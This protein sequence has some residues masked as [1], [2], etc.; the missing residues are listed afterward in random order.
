MT[1]PFSPDADLRN[2]Q[3]EFRLQLAVVKHLERAYP[4][5]VW[6][7]CPNR[8]G[9]AKDGYMKKLMGSKAGVPDI[10]CWWKDG[11]AGI[12]LKAPTGRLA[13]QQNKFLSALHSVGVHTVVC[14]SVKEVHEALKSWGLKPVCDGVVEADLRSDTQKKHDAFEYFKPEVE[15]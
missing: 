4:T 10:L 5:L 9:D 2:T 11:A 1:N 14:K 15:P 12:E 7:H 8:P 3:R 6:T 13:S